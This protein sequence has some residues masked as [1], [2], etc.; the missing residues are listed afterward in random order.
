MSRDTLAPQRFLV[1]VG[2]LEITSLALKENPMTRHK[3]LLVASH[4]NSRDMGRLTPGFQRYI[5]LVIIFNSILLIIHYLLVSFY[6]S[7]IP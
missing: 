7:K 6:R 3:P 2:Y 5:L 1:F 4:D